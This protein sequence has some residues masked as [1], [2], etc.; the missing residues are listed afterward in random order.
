[1]GKKGET[2]VRTDKM[3]WVGREKKREKEQ[4]VGYSVNG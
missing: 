3:G 4:S 1:M 2:E